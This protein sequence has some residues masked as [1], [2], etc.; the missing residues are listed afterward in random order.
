VE[1][2]GQLGDSLGAEDSTSVSGWNSCEESVI[3]VLSC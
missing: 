3:A 1:V 2:A